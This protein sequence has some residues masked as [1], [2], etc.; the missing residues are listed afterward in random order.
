MIRDFTYITDIVEGIC[1]VIQANK[2]DYKYKLYNIGNSKP[3]GL[4]E[5]IFEIENT[6]CKKANVLFDKV[7]TGDVLKTY[8]DITE[9]END[10]NYKPI[11]GIAEG[12]NNFYQW[13]K[14]YKL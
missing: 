7:R 9:L 4:M 11:T 10:F 2:L 12:I 3:V 5:F 13:Y 1:N 6:L 8:S 14:Q